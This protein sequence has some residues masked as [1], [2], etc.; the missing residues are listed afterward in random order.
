[1]V[2]NAVIIF[3]TSD[4]GIYGQFGIQPGVQFYFVNVNCTGIGHLH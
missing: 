3:H 4:S 2:I 1:M